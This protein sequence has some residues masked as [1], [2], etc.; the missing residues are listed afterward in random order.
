[1]TQRKAGKTHAGV[2]ARVCD[3]ERGLAFAVVATF[4]QGDLVG[5]GNDVCQQAFHVAGR[6]AVIHGGDDFDGFGDPFEIGLELRLEVGVQH[7][8]F[9]L[10]NYVC[11]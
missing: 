11:R 10:L 5:Q 9:S 2:D 6:L 4:H 1:M 3:E 7:D 8:Y